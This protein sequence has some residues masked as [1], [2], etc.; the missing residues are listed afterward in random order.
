MAHYRCVWIQLK[1]LDE[2][3]I[4]SPVLETANRFFCFSSSSVNKFPEFAFKHYFYSLL[5]SML[6]S[7]YGRVKSNRPP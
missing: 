5:K 6:A 1:L 2:P 4:L 3:S 7:S